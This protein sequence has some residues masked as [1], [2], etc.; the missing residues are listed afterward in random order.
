MSSGIMAIC[1]SLD[2]LHLTLL[3]FGPKLW[4]INIFSISAKEESKSAGVD[5]SKMAAW[6]WAEIWVLLIGK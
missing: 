3:S 6:Q 2:A 5:L 4:N 1:F